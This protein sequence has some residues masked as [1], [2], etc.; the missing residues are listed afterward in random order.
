[1]DERPFLKTGTVLRR[2][3]GDLSGLG[4]VDLGCGNG[5]VT[6]R[7]AALGARVVGLD[8]S[9][10]ALGAARAKG[11]GPDYRLGSAEATGLAAFSADLVVFSKSLHHVSDVEAALAE[12]R[13]ILKPGGRLAVIEPEAPDPFWPVMRWVDDEA[14]A[15]ARVRATLD[16][17]AEQA[18][19]AATA[20]LR[21]ATRFR[22]ATPAALLRQMLAID[23][24][25][26]LAEADRPAFEAA[27]AEAV[28][29]DE[30]GPY[31]VSWER[32]D[33][34]TMAAE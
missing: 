18:D 14:P 22:V 31:L 26:R 8:P 34:L 33:V 20:T 29:Q 2:R 7:L 12:A 11:G 3:L 9:E 15:Y 30:H 23:P 5:G 17:L 4:A 19:V 13:R 1:M 16:D 21:Y 24:S 32:L 25:R 27:F 6:R 28:R 10:A